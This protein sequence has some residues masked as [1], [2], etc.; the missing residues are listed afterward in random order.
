MLI[1]KLEYLNIKSKVRVYI[2][3]EYAFLLYQNDLRRNKLE[4]N[5]ELSEILY[6][7]ILQNTV[8]RRAK[9][10]T[11]AIL[12]YM[13]RTEQELRQ[14]LMLEEYPPTIID[15]TIDYIKGYGYIDD[16]RYAS[17]YVRFKKE[18]KSKFQIQNHLYQKGIA[19][20]IINLVMENE[21]ESDEVALLKAIKK[22]TDHPELLDPDK[23]QKLIAS[24]CRK[25]FH[26]EEIVKHL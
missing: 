10:K 12:K 17:N 9:Q 8:Y 4:E 14:K 3:Y 6:E 18:I 7:D 20:D 23:K 2:D 16:E 5:I 25:G 21:Y 22:K 19:K 15:K 13:D 1:T 26:Y 24:L 11:I